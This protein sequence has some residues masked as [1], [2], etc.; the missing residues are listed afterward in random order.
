MLRGVS[1][2]HVDGNGMPT[3]GSGTPK[4][5]NETPKEGSETSKDGS[6]TAKDASGTAREGR[7]EDKEG[8]G[9]VREG[10]WLE[11]EGFGFAGGELKEG[12][13]AA[14]ASA[15]SAAASAALS[16]ACSLEALALPPPP[17][18]LV[19]PSLQMPTPA[20]IMQERPIPSYV[21]S[22]H[23]SHATLSTLYSRRSSN[24]L[25]TLH[26]RQSSQ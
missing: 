10:G 11:R 9:E 2:K 7:G 26:T 14:V 21:N 5:E 20:A 25:Y 3:V 15:A 16:A 13:A 23:N 24:A 4:E 1:R 22:L 18:H 17:L 19:L 8:G 12:I 6:G